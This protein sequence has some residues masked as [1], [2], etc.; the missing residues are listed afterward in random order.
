[1]QDDTRRDA[2]AREVRLEGIAL[3]LLGAALAALVVVAFLLGRWVGHSGSAEAGSS[4]PSSGAVEEP[5]AAEARPGHF[6][7][8]EGGEKSAEPE[9]E[10]P[11]RAPPPSPAPVAALGGGSWVV[12]VFAGRDRRSAETIVRTL[13][14]RG[15][16]VGLDSQRDGRDTLF[17]VRVG[18]FRTEAEARAAADRLRSE[19]ETGAWVTRVR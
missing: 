8:V 3:L 17:R 14:A 13:S 19:G 16:P 4:G 5:P 9:R 7:S 6:D 10:V 18:G 12:Q 11:A 1:M 2:P 15:Y